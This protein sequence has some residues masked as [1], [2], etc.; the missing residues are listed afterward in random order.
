MNNKSILLRDA[1]FNATADGH[2]GNRRTLQIKEILSKAGF[3]VHD[4]RGEINI[5]KDF[6][7]K[8]IFLQLSTLSKVVP[9]FT[10]YLPDILPEY[11]RFL[12][13]ALKMSQ[14]VKL[15]EHDKTPRVILWEDNLNYL[16]PYVAKD[17]GHK[18]VSLPHNFDSLAGAD[19]NP[20][21]RKKNLDLLSNEIKHLAQ[22]DRV[23]CISR[24]E[25]WFLRL[26]GVDSDYLPYY[27]PTSVVCNLLKIREARTKSYNDYNSDSKK[28]KQ[29]LILGT[30]SNPPTRLGI[31][32]LVK[33][34]KNIEKNCS[35]EIQIAG[36]GTENLKNEIDNSS[37]FKILG[38]LSNQELIDVMI[39]TSGIL[40]YQSYGL[41]SLTKIPEML[42]AGIPIIANSI[43]SR[44][45]FDYNGIFIYE[46]NK[47]LAELIFN[48]SFCLPKLPTP[49]TQHE[50][51]FLDYITQLVKA[52]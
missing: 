41:G 36:F 12:S 2:G 6:L 24:E 44:S 20:L 40:L 48:Q 10:K 35:F 27:P 18:I 19:F 11:K 39:K 3:E 8:N 29:F 47:E 31:L 28:T 38:T 43:A 49:P 16:M 50:Y 30:Y 37:R 22:A 23:F 42:I 13:S 51:R 15:L 7:N 14:S 1:Q 25:Q 34:L 46:N 5:V 17:R 33:K 21:N 4:L 32:E 9:N 45:Y 52:N 26:C